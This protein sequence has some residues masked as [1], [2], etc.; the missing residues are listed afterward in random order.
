MKRRV[1]WIGQ[2]DLFIPTGTLEDVVP[3]YRPKFEALMAYAKSIGLTIKVRSA[4]RTCATQQSYYDLGE[5]ITQANL[6]RSMHVFGHAVDFDVVPNTCL[7]YTKLG[8]WWEK[9]GGVWGGRWKQFGACGDQGHFH[10]GMNKAQ[11]VPT[12]LCPANVTESEC[13]KIREDYLT[14]AFAKSQIATGTGGSRMGILSGLLIVGA[15]AAILYATLNVRAPVR[16]RENPH[17]D[18]K[19][20]TPAEINRELDQIDKKR[21]KLN[22]EFIEAGR[23]SETVNETWKKDDPLA[24]RYK[25]LSNR[26]GDLQREIYARYG[27]GAPSRMPKGFA[28]RR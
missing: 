27:P 25:E 8:E 11:A 13:R 17:K 12:S 9:Q 28:R 14:A 18:P 16:V 10:I 7:S 26:H 19:T 4:G 5:N 22:D 15:A 3:E 1:Q 6:C 23:G 2:V 20:M 21:S 24:L